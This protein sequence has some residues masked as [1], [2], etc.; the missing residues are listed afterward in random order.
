MSTLQKGIYLKKD[1]KG[2]LI[3]RIHPD[4]LLAY[5]GHLQP[6]KNGWVELQAVE[7]DQPNAAGS[8]HRITP[9]SS[10]LTRQ[11]KTNGP[12]EVKG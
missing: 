10:F 1:S 12:E 2:N 11:I 7:T 3:I 4:T 5:T 8:T 9:I 6:G